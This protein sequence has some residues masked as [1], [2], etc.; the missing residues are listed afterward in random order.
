MKGLKS[1]DRH[2]CPRALETYPVDQA[3]MSLGTAEEPATVFQRRL[4][5]DYILY[6]PRSSSLSPSSQ[7]R[8]SSWLTLSETDAVILEDFSTDSST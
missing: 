4:A 5:G 8:I 1:G 3:D 7:R 2:R 6:R